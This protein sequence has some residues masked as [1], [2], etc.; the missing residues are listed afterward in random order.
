MVLF[1]QDAFGM[2]PVETFF[3]D[4][5]SALAWLERRGLVV[6]ETLPGAPRW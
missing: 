2:V 4:S 3:V 5:E 1:F 6:R